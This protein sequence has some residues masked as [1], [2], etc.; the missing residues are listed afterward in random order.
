MERVDRASPFLGSDDEQVVEEEEVDGH[1]LHPAV[2]DSSPFGQFLQFSLLLQEPCLGD[3]RDCLKEI[4]RC[5]ARTLRNKSNV[6]ILWWT[7]V[8]PEFIELQ[9]LRNMD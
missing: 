8:Y 7:C 5:S 9:R 3:D 1:K 6:Q 2:K 4:F